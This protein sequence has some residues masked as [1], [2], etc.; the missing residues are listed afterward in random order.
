MEYK[1]EKHQNKQ[2]FLVNVCLMS[3]IRLFYEN[4]DWIATYM[5]LNIALFVPMEREGDV[6]ILLCIDKEGEEL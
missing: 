3:V 1:R 5:Y 4:R 6:P 2:R